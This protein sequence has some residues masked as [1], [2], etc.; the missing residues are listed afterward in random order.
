MPFGLSLAPCFFRQKIVNFSY[1]FGPF[2]PCQNRT[3][4]GGRVL[5]RLDSYRVSD[6]GEPPARLISSRRRAVV[7]MRRA[8]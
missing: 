2:L 8:K 6:L 7:D 3:L 4:L 5:V 1:L